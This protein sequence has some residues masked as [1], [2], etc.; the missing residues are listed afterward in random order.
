[1]GPGRRRLSP[2]AWKAEVQ[3][4]KYYADLKTIAK[5]A[6][7]KGYKSGQLQAQNEAQANGRKIGEGFKGLMGSL[8]TPTAKATAEIEELK[9]AVEDLEKKHTAEKRAIAEKAKNQTDLLK[10]QLEE[11]DRI[12]K[13]F[14]QDF[15][16]LRDDLVT[17]QAV[18]DYKKEQQQTAKPH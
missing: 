5:K 2:Q 11:R 4:S 8:L 18:A 10:K 9:K 1:L 16:K 15:K 17:A 12:V 13:S 7:R 3:Q 6:H 14:E